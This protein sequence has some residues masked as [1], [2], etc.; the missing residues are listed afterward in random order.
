MKKVDIDELTIGEVKQLTAMFGTNA[1]SHSIAVGEPVLIRTVT[2]YFTGRVRA[3]TASDIVLDDAA[4]IADTG[5]FADA[6]KTGKLNEVE[7]Y[8]SH[9]IIS[10]GGVIDITPWEH[11]LPRKQK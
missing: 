6:L 9:V 10:R 3:V 4:W 5:R 1:N 2:H 11:D 7:P 8:P